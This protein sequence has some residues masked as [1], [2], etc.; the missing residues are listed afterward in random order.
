MGME[1]VIDSLEDM[2]A[3]MCD[4]VIP[5]KDPEN[6]EIPAGHDSDRDSLNSVRNHTH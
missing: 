3:L 1:I 5:E 6:T 4:N 2:C